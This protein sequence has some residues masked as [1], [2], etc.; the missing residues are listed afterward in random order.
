MSGACPCG[1]QKALDVCCG[2]LI[3]G[4]QIPSSPEALMRSRYSAYTQGNIDYL[5]HTLAPEAVEGF[6]PD[7][8]REWSKSAQWQGLEVRRVSQDNDKGTGEVE[9]VAKFRLQG[10]SQYHH[11]LASFRQVDGVWKYV[12]G[13]LDPK[14][15]TQTAAKVG[16]NDPCPC[17]SGQKFKKCCGK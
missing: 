16:R 9:F 3:E 17:G 1:S 8:A 11:E 10:R 4:T 14:L 7:D 13:V 2:P 6:N 5:S 15:A 12:D